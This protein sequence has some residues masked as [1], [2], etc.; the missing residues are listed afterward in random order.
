MHERF[1]HLPSPDWRDQIVD[2]LLLDR[3]D[4]ADADAPKIMDDTLLELVGTNR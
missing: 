3:F 1:L 4:D 2:M